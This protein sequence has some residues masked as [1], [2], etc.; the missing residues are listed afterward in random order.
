MLSL[1]LNG[2]NACNLFNANQE[3][4]LYWILQAKTSCVFLKSARPECHALEKNNFQFT[5]RGL[6]IKYVI[7]YQTASSISWKVIKAPFWYEIF[8]QAL[9][10]WCAGKTDSSCIAQVQRQIRIWY[11]G[12]LS[13]RELFSQSFCLPTIRAEIPDLLQSLKGHFSLGRVAEQ[14]T[15]T[16]NQAAH[17]KRMRI[18]LVYL[19]ALCQFCL[20]KNANNLG[21]FAVSQ[22]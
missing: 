18:I 11:W 12:N 21:H 5:P 6:A 22:I 16:V 7:S 2:K 17:L 3:F 4:G 20:A 19:Y 10:L 15:T 9:R 1:H 14:I 13:E 8:L